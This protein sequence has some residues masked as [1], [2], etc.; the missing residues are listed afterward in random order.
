MDRFDDIWKNRFN[1]E[2]FSESD[3]NTPDEKVWEGIVPHVVH[4][5]DNRSFWMFWLGIGVITILLLSMLFLNKGNQTSSDTTIS[6][7]TLI[8]ESIEPTYKLEK[9]EDNLTSLTQE[10]SETSK[11]ESSNERLTVN[12]SPK[13]KHKEDLFLTDLNLNKQTV[14]ALKNISTELIS[15]D[16]NPVRDAQT[17][18]SNL[19]E[20]GNVILTDGMK[21][22]E[23]HTSE[24][25]SH[26]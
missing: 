1:E 4:Q 15:K 12:G 7:G 11:I 8:S 26:V 9:D 20:F 16:I 25:Q 14:L 3:W 5:N 19:K 10:T 13:N 22:S 2:E 18:F 23:E 24:L 21:R 17:T 6:F